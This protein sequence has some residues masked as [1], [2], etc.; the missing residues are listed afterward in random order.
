MTSVHEDSIATPGAQSRTVQIRDAG[1]SKGHRK[2]NAG[3]TEDDSTAD[4]TYT[5]CG[6]GALAS[7]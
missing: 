5:I 3:A 1:D 2:I 4:D 6:E 7:S